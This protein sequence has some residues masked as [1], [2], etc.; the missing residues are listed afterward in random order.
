MN[1]LIRSFETRVFPQNKVH[2]AFRPGDTVRVHY[3]VEEGA[4]VE[5]GEKKFR[6]QLFEGVCIRFRKGSAGASTFT[7][8]KIG[9]N[10]VGVERV[11]P[12]NSPY[13]EKVELVAAGVVR[14]ARLYYLRNLLGKA[15][16]IRKRRLPDAAVMETAPQQP[17]E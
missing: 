15:A 7:V 13:I 5:G 16:R 8:R 6:I 9:A 1:K 2:P 4:K 3:K 11:F 10:S 17:A 12:L 14:R